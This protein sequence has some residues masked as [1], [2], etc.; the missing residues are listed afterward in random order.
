MVGDRPD[1]TK[2]LGELEWCERLR[3]AAGAEAAGE[4]R[5]ARSLPGLLFPEDTGVGCPSLTRGGGH[6]GERSPRLPSDSRSRGS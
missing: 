1:Y 3:H 6:W 4:P 5:S 2:V